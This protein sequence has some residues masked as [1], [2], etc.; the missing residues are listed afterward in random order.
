MERTIDTPLPPGSTIGILGGGQLGRMLAMAAARLGFKC[1]VYSDKEEAPAADVAVAETH[2]GFADEGALETFARSVD[3][4]TYEFENVPAS[5]VAVIS[6]TTPVAPPIAALDVAQDRLREKELAHALGIGTA[7]F[8][9]VDQLGDLDRALAEIGC[10]ALLKTR[11]L[12]YDGK[13]QVK[14]GSPEEASAAIEAIA[15]APAIVESFVPF[16]REVSVLAV[17]GWDGALAFY[18]PPENRHANQI[19]Q[20][21]RVPAQISADVANNARGIAEGFARKLDYVGV[22]CIELFVVETDDGTELLVN[23]MAPRVHN[24]GHWTIE[25]CTVSQFENHIRAVAGWPLGSTARHS[26]AV[27]ENLIGH[28]ADDWQAISAQSGAALHL[29]GKSEAREGRKMGHVTR[30]SPKRTT[31]PQTS[32]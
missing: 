29:Y 28:Q 13:G 5:A 19:L 30:L 9:A 14:I 26:D 15:G 21:T 31:Q 10:P 16:E 6:R 1:H 27:M 25:A 32:R 12:G 22:L 3:V 4:V 2:A 18:D 11:R 17:R 23:E 24:S 7:A 8:A 20:E